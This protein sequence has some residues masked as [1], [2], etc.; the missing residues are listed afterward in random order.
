MKKGKGDPPIAPSAFTITHSSRDHWAP[1]P[2]RTVTAR[3]IGRSPPLE[4]M[5][6]QKDSG[7][8]VIAHNNVFSSM[9]KEKVLSGRIFL[10]SG[11]MSLEPTRT[12]QGRWG[13][14]CRTTV[15]SVSSLC[16]GPGGPKGM[17]I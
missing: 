14:G 1:Q 12:E 8:H 4:H 15:S 7:M 17:P 13:R 5:A 10:G 16:K 9:K 3:G 2:V 6:Q 11:V